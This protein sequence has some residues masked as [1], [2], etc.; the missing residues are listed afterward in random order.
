MVDIDEACSD[1]SIGENVKL[2]LKAEV[3][4]KKLGKEKQGKEK[5]NRKRK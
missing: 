5:Q 4:E 1:K 2:R 3:K